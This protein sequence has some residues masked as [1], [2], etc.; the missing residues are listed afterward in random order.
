MVICETGVSGDYKLFSWLGIGMGAGYRL[1]LIDNKAID[2]NF[3]S[4]IYVLKVKL[5]LSEIYKAVVSHSAQ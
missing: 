5:F 3:N 4:I 2:E 1:M